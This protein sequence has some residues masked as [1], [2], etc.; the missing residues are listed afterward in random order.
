V[1]GENSFHSYAAGNFA[2]SEC[3]IRTSFTHSDD[4]ALK[5]LN[6]LFLALYNPDMYIDRVPGPELGHINAHMFLFYF[7]QCIHGISFNNP[8]FFLS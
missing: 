5:Y 4:C 8:Y 3:S 2:H 1:E 6:P 7:L